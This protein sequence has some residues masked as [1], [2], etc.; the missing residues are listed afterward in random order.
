MKRPTDLEL[1]KLLREASHRVTN[2]L[3]DGLFNRLTRAA[4]ALESS[5]G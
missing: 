5:E 4:E 3:S 1:A 2:G